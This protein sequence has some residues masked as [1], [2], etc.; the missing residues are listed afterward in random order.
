M[1]F[2]FAEADK[3][4]AVAMDFLPWIILIAGT[5]ACVIAIVIRLISLALRLFSKPETPKK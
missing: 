5:V 1:N 3:T 4:L 2:F